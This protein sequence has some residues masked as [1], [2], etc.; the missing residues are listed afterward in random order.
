MENHP[1]VVDM[2]IF[3]RIFRRTVTPTPKR[4]LLFVMATGQK[5]T[6][7]S[8]GF[9]ALSASLLKAFDFD[10]GKL[11]KSRHGKRFHENEKESF[12][13]HHRDPKKRLPKSFSLRP[14]KACVTVKVSQLKYA[15]TF[16]GNKK[17]I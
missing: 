11:T 2:P 6:K 13:L 10:E 16:V 1:A 5:S 15:S 4:P 3:G 12:T 9:F 17:S 8:K 14:K 7:R